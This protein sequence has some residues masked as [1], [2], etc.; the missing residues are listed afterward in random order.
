MESIYGWN[1]S[2]V[3]F[4]VIEMRILSVVDKP[5]FGLQIGRS[6]VPGLWTEIKALGYSLT[7]I[8]QLPVSKREDIQNVCNLH[9]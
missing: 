8:P 1:Y 2:N 6:L 9:M 5:S 3:S 4:I 7:E